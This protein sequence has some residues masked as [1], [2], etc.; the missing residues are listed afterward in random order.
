MDAI[1]KLLQ[2]GESDSG[3]PQ[4]PAPL[5]EGDLQQVRQLLRQDNQFAAIQ[6][7]RQRAGCSLHEAL[8]AVQRLRLEETLAHPYADADW[9]PAA[10]PHCGAPLTEDT[11]QAIDA[12][13]ARCPFCS[14]SLAAPAEG[15]TP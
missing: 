6:F 9:I 1:K 5:A 3:Q 2:I 7:Y 4:T 11:V 8:T 12:D 14:T 10:C 15:G 13:H